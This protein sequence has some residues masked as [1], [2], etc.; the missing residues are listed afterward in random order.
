LKETREAPSLPQELQRLCSWLAESSSDKEAA[1][2]LVQLGDSLEQGRDAMPEI[3]ERVRV[4]GCISNVQ[5]YVSSQVDELGSLR[6]SLGGDAD[7]R[8]ARGL[9][10]LL[11]RGLSGLRAEEIL[12]LRSE[13]IIQS[14]NLKAFLP[15]GRNDGLRSMLT[16]FKSLIEQEREREQGQQ[17]RQDISQPRPAPE[18]QQTWAWGG[19]S[20]EVAVLLSGGVDSSVAL[21]LI[22]RQ[23]LK[24][25][26]FYLRIWLEDELAHLGECP[27][28]EDWSYATS[29]AE[30]LNVPIE[31]ISLQEEYWEQ[32][33]D[34]LIGEAKLGRTPN[35]DIM[36][37]SRIKFGMFEKYV[38]QH[39]SR[40]ASGHYA[41]SL[42]DDKEG[43]VS[44]LLMS[45][46]KIK[47][48]TYFL[49]NLRQEQL[50]HALFPIGGYTKEQ[51]RELA[52]EFDLPTQKR[53][54]SQ[55]ICFLGKL[56]FE[57]FVGHHLGENP[58]P[59]VDFHT[60]RELGEH[61]GLW[62]YTIG[63][64]KGLGSATRRVTHLGPWFVAGKDRDKNVLY[65]SNQYDTIDGPRRGFDIESIN[66]ISGEAP[67]DE[68]VRLRIKTR[69]GPGIHN[70]L[71][72]L[73]PGRLSGRVSLEG[74]DSGLAPGQ[75]AALYDG[76]E[77]VGG[78]MIADSTFLTKAEEGEGEG[79]DLAVAFGEDR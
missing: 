39:F 8:V 21:E 1:I 77:C 58:G 19:R 33:V 26:A 66:W 45:P 4:P 49:C 59:V 13:E 78:G 71:L 18:A 11:V 42:H 28:E 17:Q 60:G 3:K 54:D 62:F 20:E 14:A 40:V 51:V 76:E 23:G 27:W 52:R 47:D 7:A 65:V 6:V 12:G 43:G 67:R 35:P 32:V 75:W 57:D 38:G 73:S 37:N 44:R 25:R 10:A 55:G 24:P 79:G 69:H 46:D 9:L 34:Y 48:Q 2:R 16:T 74:R 70:G 61:R 15:T 64:R 36:C 72:T 22:R 56:K 29:V 53:K 41:V 5:V 31:S 30:R 50:K 68:E 63:Q